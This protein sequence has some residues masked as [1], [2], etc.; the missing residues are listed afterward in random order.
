MYRRT[1]C[2]ISGRREVYLGRENWPDEEYGKED[3]RSWTV[4]PSGRS[5]SS[6]TRQ[7]GLGT[8]LL[9]EFLLGASKGGRVED[10]VRYCCNNLSKCYKYISRFT[11]WLF[12]K[13]ILEYRE[14]FNYLSRYKDTWH[15]QL[16]AQAIDVRVT[17]VG[18]RRYL[19]H[20]WE[21]KAT[22]QLLSHCSSLASPE[23]SLGFILIGSIFLT[24][25]CFQELAMKPL[26][27]ER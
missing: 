6:R 11:W 20:G 23:I 26:K 8:Q 4:L 22:G 19:N 1:E 3:I 16:A 15:Q 5:P 25:V 13:S 18:K 24:A 21:N 14:S 10:I 27:P 17:E 9:I 2:F 12:N 7:R